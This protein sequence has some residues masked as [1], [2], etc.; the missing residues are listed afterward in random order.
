MP[1]ITM[2]SPKGG[3]GKTTTTMI[4]AS[5]YAEAGA[6]VCVIDADPN[7]PWLR[8]A[9]KAGKPENI[10][11]IADEGADTI[12]AN[13][14]DA[15]AKHRVV[16][17][18]LEGRRG[19]RV[20]YAIARSNLVLVPITGSELDAAETY[21]AIKIIKRAEDEFDR[22]I[23]FSAFFT[24]V[25]G[26]IRTKDHKHFEQMLISQKIPLI[27]TDLLER[28][29][30]RSVFSLGGTIHT[31]KKTDVSGLEAARANAAAFATEVFKLMTETKKAA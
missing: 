10:A 15:A 18:D 7:H 27:S 11:V 23:P 26:A 5:E 29:A 3:A 28:A 12:S 17:V 19:E 1:V 6:S 31:L 22:K 25:P 13:I 16:L 30:F 24:K 8:W 20:S 21:E 2:L 4:L 9:K 14:K